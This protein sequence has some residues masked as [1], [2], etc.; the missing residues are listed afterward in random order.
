MLPKPVLD[1]SSFYSFDLR[2]FSN[3]FCET[4]DHEK[5]IV[6]F[7]PALLFFNGPSTIFGFVVSVVVDALNRVIF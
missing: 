5:V 7:V 1:R 4:S 3:R 6:P 2:P